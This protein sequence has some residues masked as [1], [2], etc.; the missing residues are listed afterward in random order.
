MIKST[1]SIYSEMYDSFSLRGNQDNLVSRCD[2]CGDL[3]D[4]CVDTTFGSRYPMEVHACPACRGVDPP[5][6][7]DKD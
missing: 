7:T 4:D 1:R 5:T 6:P 2:C 3:S